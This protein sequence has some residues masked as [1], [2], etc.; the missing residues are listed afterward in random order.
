[1]LTFGETKIAKEKFYA[2]KTTIRVWDVNVDNKVISKLVKTKTNS[3]YLVGYLHKV[4]RSLVLISPKMSRYVKTFEVKDGDKDK[5]NKLMSFR[6][7][8]E[9]LLK[10]IKLLELRLKT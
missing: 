8:C 10:N 1:M 3:K 6:I 5:N 2:A 7:D 4:I 9:K